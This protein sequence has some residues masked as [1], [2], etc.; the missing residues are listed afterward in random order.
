MT[1]NLEKFKKDLE[2]LLEEGTR[3]QIGFVAELKKIGELS[4]ENKAAI[5]DI[6]PM[7]FSYEYERWYTE[8]SAVIKQ[9]LPDRLEDFKILYKNEKRKE[10]SYLTYTISDYMIGLV[11]TRRGNIV[12]DK[13]AALPKFQQQVR[14]LESAMSRFN[15]SIFD[16]KQMVQADIFDSELDAS[17]ELLRNGYIRASGALAG[18]VLERHLHHVIE[19]HKLKIQKKN[20]S[21]SDLNGLLKE[22]VTIDTAQ[23]R[24]IQLLGDLRNKCD[25][26]KE[27]EPTKDEINDLIVGVDK[28]IKTVS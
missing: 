27:T 4:K 19:N 13:N 22:S 16:L 8:S 24:F 7:S 6:K 18:V 21:I 28:I 25:H 15:S 11:S 14:I 9:L 20:P 2:R 17:K 5:K 1:T 3:L 10:M 12:V 26:R 23:W